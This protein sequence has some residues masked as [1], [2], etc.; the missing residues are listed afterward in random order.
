MD[1][2]DASTVSPSINSN[3]KRVACVMALAVSIWGGQ[4]VSHLF[5]RPATSVAVAAS[6]VQS[7]AGPGH[8]TAAAPVALP[9]YSS[10][11][12]TAEWLTPDQP[13]YEKIHRIAPFAL[14]N[15][16][17]QT[18][19]NGTL[20][21][22]IYVANFF[23][24][25]CPMVCPKMLANLRRIQA[26]F[27]NDAQVEL[28]SHSVMPDVDSVNVLQ[29][30]ARDNGIV[31]GKWHLLTGDKEVIYKL[32]RD[33]Y[34]AEKQ[35]RSPAKSGEFLHTESMLLI[36]GEGRIRGVYNATLPLDAERAIE[37]IRL[38]RAG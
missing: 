2:W 14:R 18:V 30:Y 6:P 9:F 38:L 7:G 3:R 25:S 37:D 22:K 5:A 28:V 13:A 1:S 32:A 20:R 35:S 36:D 24:S 10:A 16:A 26:A 17:G 19:T 27:Q 8:S 21:G 31:A 34:F 29:E 11:D 4:C 12:F 23:F 33:S 15:Q